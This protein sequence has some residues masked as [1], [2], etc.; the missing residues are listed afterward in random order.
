MSLVNIFPNCISDSLQDGT[1]G[2]YLG[3]PYSKVDAID[4]VCKATEG[5]FQEERRKKTEDFVLFEYI[6]NRKLKQLEKE[7]KKVIA[8]LRYSR[9]QAIA[10]LKYSWIQ[11]IEE[12]KH[13]Q[14]EDKERSE[15]E[16]Y[17]VRCRIENLQNT[18]RDYQNKI[19]GESVQK[20]NYIGR[21]IDYEREIS[22]LQCRQAEIQK[23]IDNPQKQEETQKKIEEI[24]KKIEEIPTKQADVKKKIEDIRKELQKKQEDI[25][26]EL[27]EKRKELEDFLPRSIEQYRKSIFEKYKK[28]ADAFESA[29]QNKI[30]TAQKYKRAYVENDAVAEFLCFILQDSF[31]PFEFECSPLIEYNKENK[32]LVVDY[33]LPTL[34]DTPNIKGIKEYKTKSSEIKYLSKTELNRLYDD[35]IYRIIIWSIAEIFHFDDL[36]KVDTV[37]FNGRVKT[38]SSATGQMHDKCLLS[39]RL[40]DRNLRP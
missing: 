6:Q 27:Q 11:E 10:M 3:I 4:E 8:M 15:N 21:I 20:Y 31:Y 24:Q 12:L 13:S 22:V 30:D 32:L 40:A 26:N 33:Y 28:I 18:I 34:E 14:K 38:R 23:E 37:C 5:L 19:A 17:T 25:Q 9:N 7:E 1:C 2:F 29:Q 35:L 36:K 16:N 39:F